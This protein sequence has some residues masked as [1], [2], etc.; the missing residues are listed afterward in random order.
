V[1]VINPG[2]VESPMTAANPYPMPFQLSAARAA[3][4]IKNSLRKGK[5]RICFP[6][7]LVAGAF[8]LSLVPPSW[9][10]RFIKL[11]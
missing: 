5:A 11:K 9:V 6:W 7:P 3:R 10:D 8:L 4:I 1:S 2:F